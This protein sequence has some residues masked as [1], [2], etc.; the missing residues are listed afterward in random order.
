MKYLAKIQNEFLKNAQTWDDLSKE[1]QE[2]Y[3]KLHPKSKKKITAKPDVNKSIET[4]KNK[5]N[6]KNEDID[7]ESF[8]G[9]YR[10]NHESLKEQFE[11][12]KFELKQMGERPP[13]FSDW[14]KE[15]YEAIDKFE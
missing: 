9:W 15:Q 10:E 12:V 1:Q 3:L 5:L 11:E 2:K 4:V 7:D 14:A 13:K 6:K 8:A